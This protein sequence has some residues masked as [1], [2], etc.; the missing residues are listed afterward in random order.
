MI[1]K[2]ALQAGAFALLAL[3]AWNAYLALGHLNQ[4]KKIAELTL[5]D[6]RMQAEISAVLRDFTDMETGQ[7]GYLLTANAPWRHSLN[8]WPL[9][10]KQKWNT[11]SLCASRATGIAHS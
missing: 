10:S 5:A 7:R 9:P 1:R 3:M 4:T 8:L 2:A 6:S 11:L